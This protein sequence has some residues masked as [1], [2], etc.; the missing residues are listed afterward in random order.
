M[1]TVSVSEQDDAKDFGPLRIMNLNARKFTI[2]D[3]AM[4]KA[5]QF[6]GK[7]ITWL[8]AFDVKKAPG[9][10][11]KVPFKVKIKQRDPN[12]VYVIKKGN[13]PAVLLNEDEVLEGDP[14]VGITTK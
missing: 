6:N 13:A 14:A 10:S 12:A 2:M 4:P 9:S 5:E 1:A 11:A 3:V 7:D 8:V